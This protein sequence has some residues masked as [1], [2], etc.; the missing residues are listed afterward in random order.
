M[1]QIHKIKKKSNNLFY[2][3]LN[4]NISIPMKGNWYMKYVFFLLF[5]RGWDIYLNKDIALNKKNRKIF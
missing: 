4:N 5:F 3:R 1:S 2:S